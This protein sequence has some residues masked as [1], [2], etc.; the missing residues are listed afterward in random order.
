MARSTAVQLY[1]SLERGTPYPGRGSFTAVRIGYM[2]KMY[3]AVPLLE[4]YYST[5]L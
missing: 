5:L 4:R 2:Y 3:T 1:L